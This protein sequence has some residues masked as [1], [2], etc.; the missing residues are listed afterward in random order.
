MRKEILN[1]QYNFYKNS[2]EEAKKEK[3]YTKIFW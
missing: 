1:Y 2:R 3:N